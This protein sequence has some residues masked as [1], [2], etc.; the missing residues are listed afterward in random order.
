MGASLAA[1]LAVA[2]ISSENDGDDA[3]PGAG[4]TAGNSGDPADSAVIAMGGQD[5]GG[6]DAGVP[7]GAAAACVPVVLKEPTV[8]DL[9]DAGTVKP[10]PLVPSGLDSRPATTTC[11]PFP[12][13]TGQPNDPFPQDLAA[14][15][16][17]TP[18]NLREVVQGPIPYDLN[19][20]LWSDGAAKRR[21]M[22]LPAG[23]KIAIG[24][25]GHF[26]FPI[27]TMLIKSFE[28]DGLMLETRFLVRHTDGEWA[29][30]TYE[31]DAGGANSAKLHRSSASVRRIGELRWVFPGRDNCLECHTKPA[32]RSL[33]PEVGQLNRD[34]VYP[35]GRRANQLA[36][37]QQI[38]L[39]ETALGDL[40]KL[41]RFAQP[42]I[43]ST[44]TV[45]ERARAYLHAN[46]AHCH[47]PGG[48]KEN[49]FDLRVA[50]PL[51]MT[52]TVQVSPIRGAFGLDNS[53]LIA[54]GNP[55]NSMIYLRMG[56]LVADIRM[57]TIGSNKLDDVGLTL[58][59][60]WVKSLS[61][62]TPGSGRSN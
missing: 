46:C 22:V 39:F 2:C 62:K 60:A 13:P 25:N 32:G 61:C 3:A 37:Y 55:D 43:A 56:S 17:F 42:A 19:S 12:R 33:G 26:D 14:T 4:G 27:G 54:P 28:L 6:Q 18:G 59:K 51:D 52:S 41:T 38:G 35:N 40:A 58:V 31:W 48:T 1:L 49:F 23:G 24:R 16:C 5:G 53:H 8:G 21:W 9:V 57:P 50:T 44:G 29:G 45:A 47:Q 36:T 10:P 11:L 34:F 20:P 7:D 15:G 30:Y